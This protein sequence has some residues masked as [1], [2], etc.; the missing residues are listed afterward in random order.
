MP[1]ETELRQ[2]IAENEY[3]LKMAR[4][5]VADLK[6]QLTDAETKL[7]GLK[8]KNDRLQEQLRVCIATTPKP[9]DFKSE[10][11]QELERFRARLPALLEKLK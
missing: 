11:D 7:I 1:T 8:I 10:Q 6:E 9:K 4:D 3:D 5:Q 2:Q